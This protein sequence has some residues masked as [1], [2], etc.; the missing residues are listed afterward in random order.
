MFYSSGM[1][2]FQATSQGWPFGSEKIAGVASP[3]RIGCRFEHLRTGCQSLGNDFIC[4]FLAT[5]IVRQSYAAKTDALLWQAGILS[6][7]V[8]W[9]KHQQCA[10]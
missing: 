1:N 8:G 3:D 9:V 2:G 5:A 4:L 6:Q 7:R 10:F